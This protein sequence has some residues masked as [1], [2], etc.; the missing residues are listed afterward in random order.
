[1]IRRPPRSTRTDTLFPYTTLFRSCAAEQREVVHRL[2]DDAEAALIFAGTAVALC[3]GFS[4]PRQIL[5]IAFRHEL[6]CFVTKHEAGPVARR[7]VELLHHRIYHPHDD[8]VEQVRHGF[9]SSEE[10][11]VG[12]ECVSTCISRCSPYN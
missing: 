11:R 7:E 8:D 2:E 3:E 6:R 5:T 12:N 1:M 10:R 4:Q 9:Q